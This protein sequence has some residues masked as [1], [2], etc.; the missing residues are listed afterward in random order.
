MRDALAMRVLRLMA[1]PDVFQEKSDESRL[2]LMM[3]LW[4]DSEMAF[5]KTPFRMCHERCGSERQLVDGELLPVI[6]IEACFLS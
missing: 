1:L 2:L 3:P 5:R 4:V 6:N